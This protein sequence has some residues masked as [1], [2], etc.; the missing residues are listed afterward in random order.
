MR[1]KIERN[2]GIKYKCKNINITITAITAITAITTITAITAI[3]TIVAMDNSIQINDIILVQNFPFSQKY[4]DN[5]EYDHWFVP[6]TGIYKGDVTHNGCFIGYLIKD[7][8]TSKLEIFYR[9]SD[10]TGNCF[11]TKIQQP[12]VFAPFD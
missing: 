9:L 4:F 7:I 6:K 8:L 11:I 3:T 2:I 5:A 10:N 1:Q 12:D